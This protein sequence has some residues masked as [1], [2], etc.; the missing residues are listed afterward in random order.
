MTSSAWAVTHRAAYTEFTH[1]WEI[2]D[3]RQA[4]ELGHMLEPV[5]CPPFVIPG[6][7][8]QVFL[9]LRD[10]ARGEGEG[11]LVV[12][13][14]EVELGSAEDA[15]LAARLEITKMISAT[16]VHTETV[17]LG[18]VEGHRMQPSCRKTVQDIVQSQRSWDFD[19]ISPIFHSSQ[20]VS[21]TTTFWVPDKI[22]SASGTGDTVETGGVFDFRQLLADP[23]DSD[24][25]LECGGRVFRCH[26]VILRARSA[27]FDR[28]LD[29]GMPEVQEGRVVVDDLQPE[30]LDKLLEYVYTGEVEAMEEDISELLYAGDKYQITGLVKLCARQFHTHVTT[31]TAADILLLADRH[32]LVDLKQMVM[33]TILSDK[34]T[35]LADPEFTRKM[36]SPELLL[37]LLAL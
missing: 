3:L 32:H 33:M 12:S 1:S 24:I 31:S 4:L 26:R 27:V 25:V 18:D 35:F 37:E 8:G 15:E 16:D 22:L 9:R 29:S 7:P 10:E 21:L 5:D 36:T 19:P 30:V 34:A 20:Q 11:C 14:V 2:R 6:L 17:K 13:L 28:M 23:R